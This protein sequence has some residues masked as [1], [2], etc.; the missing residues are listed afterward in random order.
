MKKTNF[1]KTLVQVQILFCKK[2]WHFNVTILHRIN[3][4]IKEKQYK[5]NMHKPSY[6][7]SEYGKIPP[8]I[9]YLAECADSIS[10]SELEKFS[11]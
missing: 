9:A 7:F 11:N 6:A 1:I 10:L 4:Y 5:R 3:Y 2:I 8:H